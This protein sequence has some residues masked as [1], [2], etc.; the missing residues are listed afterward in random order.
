M[1]FTVGVL[2]NERKTTMNILNMIKKL[3]SVIIAVFVPITSSSPAY[4]ITAVKRKPPVTNQQQQSTNNSS[5]EFVKENEANSNTADNTQDKEE[6]NNNEA[7]NA[8]ETEVWDSLAGENSTAGNKNTE[9]DKNSNIASEEALETWDISA[10]EGDDVQM[11]FYADNTL[12]TITASLKSIFLPMT[13]YAAEVQLEEDENNGK[14]KTV[15][16]EEDVP[17][18]T[19]R[20]T[21][22]GEMETAVYKKLVSYDRYTA[23]MKNL[24]ADEFK[25]EA[26]DVIISVPEGVDTSDFIAVDEAA[27]FYS[28]STGQKFY[29]TDSMRDK[30]DPTQFLAFNPTKIVIE[31]GVTNISENAFVMCGSVDTLTIPASLTEIE[32]YAFMYCK[33]IKEIIFEENSSLVSIGDYAFN[34]CTGLTEIK[35]PEGL[36]TINPAAFENCS[37]LKYVF[38]PQ[39]IEVVENYAFASIAPDARII[40]PTNAVS[41][42]LNRYYLSH[43]C[44][45]LVL[46]NPYGINVDPYVGYVYDEETGF[47][48]DAERNL[49]ID[50]DTD[51]FYNKDTLE[52]VDMSAAA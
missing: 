19:L 25:V 8:P 11:A 44:D 10:T 26:D 18:G 41:E 52:V 3:I 46:E 20:I 33:G 5:M 17:T 39:S 28:K 48:Y 37:N 4:Q 15:A 47:V 30:L 24:I 42:V 9:N 27:S 34:Y 45:E 2:N 29:I 12:D 35:L 21:G 1:R 16:V 6:A 36:K 43:D 22:S 7:V 38:L 13:V 40:C 32:N 49:L 51:T 14:A 31:S 23:T 50:I